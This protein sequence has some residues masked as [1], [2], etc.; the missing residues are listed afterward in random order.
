MLRF[1]VGDRVLGCH[2][3]GTI[4]GLNGAR[5]SSATDYLLSERGQDALAEV[6]KVPILMAGLMASMNDGERW[7][8]IV[9]FDSGVQYSY[10]DEEW[11]LKPYPESRTPEDDLK[12]AVDSCLYMATCEEHERPAKAAEWFAKAEAFDAKLRA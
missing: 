7:P 12:A 9:R 5:R 2:G 3:A 4:V 10:T 11:D 8:Y 6:A 1:K